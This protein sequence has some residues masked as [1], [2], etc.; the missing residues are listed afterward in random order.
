[1]GNQA[2]RES[3]SVLPEDRGLNIRIEEY[4]NTITGISYGSEKSY[5]GQAGGEDR[6]GRLGKRGRKR[7]RGAP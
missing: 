1:M 2:S 6:S 4:G 7:Q 5:S 3:I